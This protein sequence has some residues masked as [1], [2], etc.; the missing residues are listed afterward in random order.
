MNEDELFGSSPTPESMMTSSLA[1]SN[2]TSVKTRIDI[3]QQ[4]HS[5]F[6]TLAYANEEAAN[7]LLV[8]F[9][10][11]R[12]EQEYVQKTVEEDIVAYLVLLSTKA[13]KFD[14]Q[15]V[16]A[17]KNVGTHGETA[18]KKQLKEMMRVWVVEE[19]VWGPRP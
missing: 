14:R 8:A 18:Q 2:E 1:A 5:M 12:Q 3:R 6:H 11:H 9:K 13:G 19:R 15:E 4:D 17:E 7:L 16:L 10:T